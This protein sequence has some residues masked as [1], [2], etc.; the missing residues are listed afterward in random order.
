M[1]LEDQVIF[2]NVWSKTEIINGE[3]FEKKLKPKYCI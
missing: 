1:D 3:E 2:G